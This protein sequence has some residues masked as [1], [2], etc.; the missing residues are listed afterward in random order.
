MMEERRKNDFTII[1][2]LATIANDIV[3]LKSDA[4]QRNHRFEKHLI[5]SDKFRTAVERN[6]TWRHAYKL[7]FIIVFGILSFVAYTV[8]VK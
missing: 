6:T 5:S 7:G 2:K 1:K 3:W 4:V 8:Y